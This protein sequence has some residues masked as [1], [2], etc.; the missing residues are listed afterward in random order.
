MDELWEVGFACPVDTNPA[1]LLLPGGRIDIEPLQSCSDLR[2]YGSGDFD[3]RIALA[4]YNHLFFKWFFLAIPVEHWNIRPGILY[5]KLACCIKNDIR[6]L[7]CNPY[8][9]CNKYAKQ[10]TELPKYS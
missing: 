1:H 8:N 3:D 2:F 4:Q 7:G 6:H 9:L 10:E 5:P